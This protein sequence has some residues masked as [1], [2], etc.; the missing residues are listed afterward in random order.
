MRRTE[1]EMGNNREKDKKEKEF[2]GR[3]KK[4]EVKEEIKKKSPRK[5]ML[6]RITKK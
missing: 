4:E 5:Y 6:T 2:T 1:K 3:I